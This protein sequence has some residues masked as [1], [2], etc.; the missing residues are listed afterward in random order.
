MQGE[1]TES[2]WNL[3]LWCTYHPSMLRIFFKKAVKKVARCRC[4]GLEPLEEL[5]LE[6][7]T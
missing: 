7:D 1:R 4:I 5:Q 6:M 2:V 3:R